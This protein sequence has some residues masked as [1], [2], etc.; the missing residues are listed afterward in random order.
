MYHFFIRKFSGSLK[1]QITFKFSSQTPSSNIMELVSGESSCLSSSSYS[2]QVTSTTGQQLVE[3]SVQNDVSST[4]NHVLGTLE[5][6]EPIGPMHPIVNDQTIIQSDQRTKSQRRKDR[7]FQEK[8]QRQIQA[9]QQKHQKELDKLHQRQMKQQ[10][11]RLEQRER[12][13][14]E[15]QRALQDREA[16]PEHAAPINT[17]TNPTTTTPRDANESIGA[18]EFAPTAPCWISTVF[19]NYRRRSIKV[20]TFIFPLNYQWESSSSDEEE[21]YE[22]E[23][24]WWQEEELHEAYDNEKTPPKQ[25]W[26]QNE[27]PERQGEDE[28]MANNITSD[29]KEHLH[30]IK[31]AETI[32]EQDGH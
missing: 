23:P 2:D 20:T 24:E 9:L 13:R 1:Q 8:Q 26:E 22:D 21:G 14:I 15:R 12:Y 27:P 31:L 17:N 3:A 25:E 32:F 4:M 18:F 10:K 19:R 11:Q 16:Q 5:N 30:H 28:V 29:E 6:E 7:R